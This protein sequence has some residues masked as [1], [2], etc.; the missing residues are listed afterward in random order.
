MRRLLLIEE[1]NLAG[2]STIS[3]KLMLRYR[4]VGLKIVMELDT[5][6]ELNAT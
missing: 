1:C 2:V 5:V 6:V 3:W 4:V